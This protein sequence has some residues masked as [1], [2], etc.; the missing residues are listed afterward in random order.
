LNRKKTSGGFFATLFGSKTKKRSQQSASVRRALT[1]PGQQRESNSKH[2]YR[3]IADEYPSS[4]LG[5]ASGSS[6][7][8]PTNTRHESSRRR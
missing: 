1:K 2:I 8:R 4:D 6:G 3:E 7:R 5:T